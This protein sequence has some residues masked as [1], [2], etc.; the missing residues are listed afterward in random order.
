MR[1]RFEMTNIGYELQSIH[2]HAMSFEEWHKYTNLM[3]KEKMII[4]VIDSQMPT[5]PYVIDRLREIAKQLDEMVSVVDNMTVP[6]NDMISKYGN[7][8]ILE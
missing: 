1:A 6:L 4:E 2:S 7:Q 8:K 5:D 3:G